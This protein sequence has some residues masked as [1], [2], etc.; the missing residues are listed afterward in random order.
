MLQADFADKEEII[1]QKL[2]FIHESMSTIIINVSKHS[3]L[4][5]SN[6]ISIYIHIFPSKVLY[7]VIS[8]SSI[9]FPN[10]IVYLV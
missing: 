9:F 6:I 5:P 10:M 8:I 7:S 3:S 2:C 4:Y 1:D